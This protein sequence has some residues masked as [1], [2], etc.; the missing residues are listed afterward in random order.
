MPEPPT[1]ARRVR[2]EQVMGTAV[3]VDLRDPGVPEPALDGFFGWLRQ[4]D[5]RFSTY[6]AGSEISRIGRGE[7]APGS[8]H[9]DV[10]EVL[11]ICEEVRRCSGGLFAAW[12]PDGGLDPSAVV[13]GWSVERGARLLE[14]AGA[15]N[16]CI[17]A[18][19]DVLARGEPEPGRRWR[20][21]IRHPEIADRVAAVLG[22]RDLAVATSGTY[23][24]GAHILDPRSGLPACGL[25]SLTV[26]G[27]SLTLA[28][29]YSTAAFVMGR[30]GASWIAG[31][32]GYEAF[33]VT[34]EHRAV[35][36]EGCRSLRVQDMGT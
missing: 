23:E 12:R 3:G 34:A 1:T 35:W 6:R 28:D 8:A 21:G 32:P 22:V 18:G 25:L 5:A 24:R 27:P 17:N 20:V 9:P 13:K 15:R 29:A 31:I 10:R 2:V 11:E 16:F 33:A 36:T 19:G 26:V 30:D 4:V 7:L 14:D